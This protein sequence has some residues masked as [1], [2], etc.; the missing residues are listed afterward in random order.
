MAEGSE[1]QEG[2]SI[3]GSAPLGPPYDADCSSAAHGILEQLEGDGIADHEIVERCA[4]LHV[5]A[6]KVDRATAAEADEPV[7]LPEQQ[8]DD[9]P[10]RRMA[11]PLGGLRR[12]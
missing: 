3:V 9:A 2:A 5:A 4:L 10:R 12:Q 1:K 7:A 11:P 6:M 8:L